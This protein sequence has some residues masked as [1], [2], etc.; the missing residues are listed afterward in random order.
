VT[1]PPEGNV[2]AVGAVVYSA[3]SL[4]VELPSF[5][6]IVTFPPAESVTAIVALPAVILWMVMDF[7]LT[8][9]FTKFVSLLTAV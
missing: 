2:T 1:V 9:T 8:L 4:S 5:T 6:A 3:T 7:P